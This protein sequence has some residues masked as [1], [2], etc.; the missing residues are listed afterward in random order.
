MPDLR[1]ELLE[2]RVEAFALQERRDA[3]NTHD[4]VPTQQ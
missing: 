1:L 3:A 2:V 4:Q